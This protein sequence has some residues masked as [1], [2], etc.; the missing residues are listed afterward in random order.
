MIRE[1]F[2]LYKGGFE[3]WRYIALRKIGAFKIQER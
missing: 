3:N 1:I 2:M